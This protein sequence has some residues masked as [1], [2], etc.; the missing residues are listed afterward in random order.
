MR[1]H[2][3]RAC[4][5]HGRD[6]CTRGAGPLV[7]HGG[8]DRTEPGAGRC[9]AD[10][11]GVDLPEVAT[12]LTALMRNDARLADWP[13]LGRYREANRALPA[14]AAGESAGRVHGRFDHR[15]VAAAALCVL[16]GQALRRSRHQRPDDAADAGAV[17]PRR[18]RAEAEG[19]GDPRRHERHRRQHRADDRRGHRGEPRVDERARARATTSRWCCRASRRSSAYH[20]A[21]PRAVPQTTRQADGAHPERSTTGS[22]PTRRPTTTP[23]WITSRA[24]IDS[25]RAD[26]R[27]S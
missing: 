17:P 5:P 26:A 14:A 15:C 7:H 20:T 13:A 19:G 21:A 10:G 6:C 25:V 3:A 18:H 12:A 9:A 27:R 2:V 23:T 16:P 24:M 8:S 4:E 11:T 1:P 22:R